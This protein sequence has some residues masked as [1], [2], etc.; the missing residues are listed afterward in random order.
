MTSLMPHPLPS[1][2]FVRKVNSETSETPAL[3][4]LYTQEPF[5]N[6]SIR[7]RH[8][9]LCPMINGFSIS[10][11][12]R[13]SP[14]LRILFQ[15]KTF[16]IRHEKKAKSISFWVVKLCKTVK[17]NFSNYDFF[18]SLETHWSCLACMRG[19]YELLFEEASLSYHEKWCLKMKWEKCFS[20]LMV[21][22]RVCT[23]QK[24]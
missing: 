21:F 12:E 7:L 24:N 14:T 3:I 11:A 18:F 4:Q 6:S 23:R 20:F 2:G 9:S 5:F 8:N 22:P 10:R 19:K 1:V 17:G 16:I 15:L 13:H